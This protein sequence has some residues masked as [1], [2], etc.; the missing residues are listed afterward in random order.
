MGQEHAYKTF[1]KMLQ[2]GVFP[3]VLLLF[4]KEAYLVD[5]AVR[6]TKKLLLNPASLVMDL[7]RFAEDDFT[8]ADIVNAS[9]TPPMLS[10]RKIVMVED[11]DL[12][13]AG[14]ALAPESGKQSELA[15][16]IKDVPPTTLLIFTATK[17][18][19]RKRLYKEIVK[20][21]IAYEF[22]SIEG[23]TLTDFIKKRIN[24]AGKSALDK[25]IRTFVTMTGYT[26]K[27]SDYTLYNMVND[28]K[29]ATA[30]TAQSELTL[31]D[32]QQTTAGNV[33]TDV[34]KLLDAAF[35]GD[36]NK[37]LSLLKNMM[38]A[39]KQSYASGVALRFIGLICAQLEIMLV[40]KE[41][42]AEGQPY[43]ALAA[44]MGIKP[45]RLQ[46]ALEAA[47]ERT[48]EQLACSLAASFE[49]EQ[50]IKRS[51]MPASLILELFIVSL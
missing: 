48:I 16:Y 23:K 35:L 4:G 5:W 26:D 46:K 30:F 1:Q 28:L 39:E 34:F 25:D 41:R 7:N 2:S 42:L 29:K 45:F 33:D 15:A 18:D 43:G 3:S 14:Q 10:P 24:V 32:F 11:C 51:D 6:E 37:A 13:F 22:K 47:G 20:S 36:K 21:G 50:E 40:A 31:D 19:K 38:S 27:D 49:M 44:A 9:E 12:L 17:V 8:A